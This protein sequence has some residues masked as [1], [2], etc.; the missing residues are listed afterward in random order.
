MVRTSPAP[1]STS[2]ARR[3]VPRDT[4][5]DRRLAATVS[6]WRAD[7][8][9]AALAERL[10]ASPGIL[11]DYLGG[12]LPGEVKH[13]GGGMLRLDQMAVDSLRVRRIEDRWDVQ[14]L[15]G[16]GDERWP[17]EEEKGP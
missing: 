3:A 2:T 17:L 6:T 13:L 8:G 10:A 5:F 4:P 12:K 9:S 7:V 1:R 14:M 15:I 11:R 16:T